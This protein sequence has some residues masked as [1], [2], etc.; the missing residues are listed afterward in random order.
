MKS[1]FRMFLNEVSEYE[2]L[3]A[4]EEKE[5]A[6]K[7]KDGDIDAR[8]RLIN[9]N[10]RLVVSVAKNYNNS[11]M[12]IMDLIS[13]GVMGLMQAVDKFNPD[14]GYR[15][16][17]CATPWIKQAITKAIIDKGRSIRTPAHIYQ[18]LNKYRQ[19]IAALVTEDNPNPTVEQ[20]AKYM[21]VSE[22]RVGELENWRYDTVSLSTPI[23]EDEE[24]TLEDMQADESGETPEAYTERM[25]RLEHIYS[26]IDTLKPRTQSIVK[27]RFGLGKDTDPEEYRYE[28]TLE[29]IGDILNLTRER[30]RQILK[31]ALAEIKMGWNTGF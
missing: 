3:S 14:L 20:I 24:E 6:R 5:L 13:E 28:H 2:L 21:G 19:A 10:L 9:S 22:E 11:H 27:M 1:A 31:D 17:T 26:L 30:V 25:A 18:A 7:Y 12:E 16:S 29:E 15:F 23:G 8:E 4:D